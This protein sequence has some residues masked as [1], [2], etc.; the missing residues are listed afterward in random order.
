MKNES[1]LS[2]AFPRFGLTFRLPI[3]GFVASSFE[4]FA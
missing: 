4:T 2:S 3:F 1:F